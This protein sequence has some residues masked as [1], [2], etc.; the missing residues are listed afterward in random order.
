MLINTL[1]NKRSTNE[2]NSII[3]KFNNSTLTLNNQSHSSKLCQEPSNIG[4]ENQKPNQNASKENPVNFYSEHKK[5]DLS[6]V[7]SKVDCCN[8][9]KQST[10]VSAFSRVSKIKT[11]LVKRP[12]FK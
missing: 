1:K 11:N 6:K 9:K 8:N 5:I 12:P 3:D 10:S 2:I 7:C 4:Q